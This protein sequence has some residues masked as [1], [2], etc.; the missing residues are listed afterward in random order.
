MKSNTICHLSAL[1]VQFFYVK[2]D[3]TYP[4]TSGARPPM[5]LHRAPCTLHL[6][7]WLSRTAFGWKH[8]GVRMKSLFEAQLQTN[9][10]RRRMSFSLQICG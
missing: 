6:T 9:L 4:K 1:A 5:Q 10:W 2:M 3:Q 7:V 8:S